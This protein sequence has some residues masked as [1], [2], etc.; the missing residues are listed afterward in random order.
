MTVNQLLGQVRE[1]QDRHPRARIIG[2]LLV[3]CESVER[4]AASAA[5]NELA[6]V[7]VD[8]AIALFDFTA[9]LFTTYRTA[10]GT[11]TAPERGAARAA[12]EARLPIADWLTRLLCPTNGKILCAQDVRDLLTETP[13]PPQV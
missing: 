9:E 3:A 8:A 11:G 5:R 7:H 12:V 10:S 4:D 6:L 13:S 2:C 1:E